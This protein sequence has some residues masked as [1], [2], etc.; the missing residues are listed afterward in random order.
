MALSRDRGTQRQ[1]RDFAFGL[2][3]DED[4]AM[5]G[6]YVISDANQ[7]HGIVSRTGGIDRDIASTFPIGARL[8]VLPT[9]RAPRAR[10]IPNTTRCS[11]DGET[12]VWPRFY[13]W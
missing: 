7:E 12:E 8:R 4:G 10:S 1:Q 2:V 11:P 5:L 9:T 6:D 13:G 3:C